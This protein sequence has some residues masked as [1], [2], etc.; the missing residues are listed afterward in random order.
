MATLA[1]ASTFNV[2]RRDRLWFVL[3]VLVAV[4]TLMFQVYVRS[5]Q[6]A[7]DCALSYAK[8][9]V[10]SSIWPVSWTVYLAGIV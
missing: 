10:W 4:L 5:S 7:P 8:A 1:Q 6:C 2:G 3:Y 9:V